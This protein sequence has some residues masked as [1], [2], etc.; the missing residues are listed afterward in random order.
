MARMWKCNS[1]EPNPPIL[2]QRSC[3]GTRE[4][5]LQQRHQRG[6]GVDPEVVTALRSRVEKW[7]QQ[8]ATLSREWH[9]QDCLEAG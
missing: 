6:Q 9:Q 2:S 5:L 4:P 3:T 7:Q 1:R 8:K